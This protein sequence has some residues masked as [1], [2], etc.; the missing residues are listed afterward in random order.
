M[1]LEQIQSPF[2]LLQ[3]LYWKAG[4]GEETNN[5]D[6]SLVVFTLEAV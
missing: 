4:A 2:N 1:L 6:A 5:L 3:H